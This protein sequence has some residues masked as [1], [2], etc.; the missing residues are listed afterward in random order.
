LVYRFGRCRTEGQC[1]KKWPLWAALEQ[2]CN[3]D[4]YPAPHEKHDL[5]DFM[6]Q[7]LNDIKPFLKPLS[8][9]TNYNIHFFLCLIVLLK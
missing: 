2:I 1:F 6:E 9:D 8:M 7:C 3:P 4:N 5:N